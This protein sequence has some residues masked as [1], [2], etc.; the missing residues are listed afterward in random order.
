MWKLPKAVESKDMAK[1]SVLGMPVL[2]T[3]ENTADKN[4][5]ELFTPGFHFFPFPWTETILLR[6]ALGPLSYCCLVPNKWL[7]KTREYNCG[8]DIFCSFSLVILPV[9]GL[10]FCF[11]CLSPYPFNPLEMMLCFVDPA[12][13][14]G[15]QEC[16]GLSA[17]RC[18]PLDGVFCSCGGFLVL[19][20]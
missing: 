14:V 8:W 1:T 4:L 10:F 17:C 6:R 9:S 15:V 11:G 2:Q 7:H 20:G 16:C 18:S 13:G 5:Y 19:S 12:S 3:K